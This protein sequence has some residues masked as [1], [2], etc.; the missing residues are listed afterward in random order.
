MLFLFLC[1]TENLKISYVDTALKPFFHPVREDHATFPPPQK[2]LPDRVDVQQNLSKDEATLSSNHLFSTVSDRHSSMDSSEWLDQLLQ[3]TDMQQSYTLDSAAHSFSH[4]QNPNE[5][6]HALEVSKTGSFHHSGNPT[7][8]NSKTLGDVGSS[9]VK[10]I[11]ASQTTSEEVNELEVNDPYSHLKQ[12]E[13]QLER[14]QL[15]LGHQVTHPTETTLS[16]QNIDFAYNSPDISANDKTLSGTMSQNPNHKSIEQTSPGKTHLGVSECYYNDANIFEDDSSDH[17][18]CIG[19]RNLRP[20]NSPFPTNI[21]THRHDIGVKSPEEAYPYTTP[22][23]Q[24]SVLNS[25]TRTET[26]VA[27]HYTSDTKPSNQTVPLL[28]GNILKNAE[29]TD[30]SDNEDEDE[31]LDSYPRQYYM[32]RDAI[33]ATGKQHRFHSHRV[34]DTVS[35]VGVGDDNPATS[36]PWATVLDTSSAMQHTEDGQNERDFSAHG[37]STAQLD[38]RRFE[39]LYRAQTRKVE[40]LATMLQEVR[41]SRQHE[42]AEIQSTLTRTEEARDKT[43]LEMETMQHRIQELEVDVASKSQMLA[44]RDVRVR[45]LQHDNHALEVEVDGHN[46]L[47]Q[48]LQYQLATFE[49]ER[50][51]KFS[52]DNTLLDSVRSSYEKEIAALNAT[53]REQKASHLKEIE[54]MDTTIRELYHRLSEAET[55]SRYHHLQQQPVHL[56]EEKLSSTD[57]SSEMPVTRD[58]TDRATSPINLPLYVSQANQTEIAN[59]LTSE[60]SIN[61]SNIANELTT[62]STGELGAERIFG[63]SNVKDASQQPSTATRAKQYDSQDREEDEL[64]SEVGQNN[65][66]VS[67]ALL[68]Y[69]PNPDQLMTEDSVTHDQSFQ[70]DTYLSVPYEQPCRLGD[71]EESKRSTDIKG[72]SNPSSKN[73]SINVSDTNSKEH[74][75]FNSTEVTPRAQ[76]MTSVGIQTDL[77]SNN[78]FEGVKRINE[79]SGNNT[80]SHHNTVIAHERGTQTSFEMSTQSAQDVT[81]I[82]DLDISLIEAQQRIT[83]VEQIRYGIKHDLARLQEQKQYISTR[84]EQL[85]NRKHQYENLTKE[86]TTLVHRCQQLK[87]CI[88]NLI[89][90]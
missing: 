40:E 80:T 36:L 72:I 88:L 45:Q 63:T 42:V 12:K 15:E 5:T 17:H 28:K 37:P 32:E 85:S 66:L 14:D 48:Q 57:F 11:G 1:L 25:L 26:K 31:E 89:D 56:S 27:D 65:E 46:A 78:F 76:G 81:P 64:V 59:F 53:I 50:H 69:L 7:L 83:A 23:N 34:E 87:V 67:K 68:Q 52:H 58:M 9:L 20:T 24:G 70:N 39:I 8:Q 38:A 44:D 71:C 41:V 29:H 33:P 18:T 3:Q 35:Q 73:E 21:S 82:P 60:Y 43:L 10:N 55:A 74:A 90:K 16:N 51:Q 77:S 79:V 2:E 86:K 4:H 84:I 19:N 62:A 47:I 6:P 61:R 49:K 30:N 75:I 13:Q 54:Q 22:Q